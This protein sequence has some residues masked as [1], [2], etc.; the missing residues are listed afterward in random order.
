MDRSKVTGIEVPT[1]EHAEVSQ[2]CA[3]LE[4]QYPSER[5]LPIALVPFSKHSGDEE[6]TSKYVTAKHA[7]LTRRI[8]SQFVDRARLG[9]RNALKWS[10]SNIALAIFA[11]MGGVPW[12]VKPSTDRCLIVGVGQAHR[13][14]NGQV[15]KYVAY[16]VLTDSSGGYETIKMLGS[17]ATKEEYLQRLH[18]NLRQ[19]LLVR[20]RRHRGHR[21]A[22]IRARV[23][24]CVGISEDSRFLVQPNGSQVVVQSCRTG[25]RLCYVKQAS[26]LAEV[27]LGRDMLLH[28][29]NFSTIS[30]GS[31]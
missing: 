3:A 6:V 21:V 14:V 11:K 13:E 1:F 28:Q 19:V 12:R 20:G 31:A 2:A 24:E 10:I 25:S 8:A 22:G 9:D 30:P 5:L 4:R 18:D 27:A 15:E 23:S 26:N 29:D 7:F 17:A 16:S